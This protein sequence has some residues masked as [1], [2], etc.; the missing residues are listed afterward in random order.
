M[1][2]PTI[3]LLWASAVLLVE[4]PLAFF[5]FLSAPGKNLNRL[6]G[7]FLFLEAIIIAG[8]N[9]VGAA[10]PAEFRHGINALGAIS[11]S[12]AGWI[13]L[14]F[15]G[16]VLNT[17]MVRA[18]KRPS[19]RFALIAL[20]ILCAPLYFFVPEQFGHFE[21]GPDGTVVLASGGF[22]Q[23]FF[24]LGPALLFL[25]AFVAALHAY[26]RAP[27]GTVTRQRSKL[28][29]LSFGIRDALLGT[30]L[31]VEATDAARF[32]RQAE[33]AG[34]NLICAIII[35]YV[36]L[37][38]YALLRWELFDFDVKLKWS[39]RK[40]T[41][42]G[43]FVAMFFIVN[44]LVEVFAGQAFG[45][46]AGAI[47]AGLLLFALRPLERLSHRVADA[48]MP[49][50]HATAEYAAFR[51]LEVYQ[52]A[53][54]AALEGGISPKERRTLDALRTKLGIAEGDAALVERDAKTTLATA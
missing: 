15:L 13:Y 49:G 23:A 24:N 17:P 33:A 6:L 35:L 47:A 21:E 48:A 2:A 10:L 4:W 5:I 51:K 43:I 45:A 8:Y 36:G 11:I 18:L 22:L 38:A 34:V 52:A 16:T 40:G 9:G 26:R 20:A 41:L 42:A 39:I 30:V 14:L 27:P 44:Q 53:L 28:Y 54:E 46:V 37:L 32:I 7:L 29:A 1:D 50:V 12:V 31:I 19:V 25:Y 3:N